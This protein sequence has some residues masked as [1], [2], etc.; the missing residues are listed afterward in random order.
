MAVKKAGKQKRR[1]DED[2][3]QAEGTEKKKKRR[4]V[5]STPKYSGVTATEAANWYRAQS[6][7][8]KVPAAVPEDTATYAFDEALY[9]MPG[10]LPQINLANPITDDDVCPEIDPTTMVRQD[11]DNEDYECLDQDF[12][13]TLGINKRQNKLW[14]KENL[15]TVESSSA[16]L[17]AVQSSHM[18]QMQR[19]HYM[20][21]FVH[22][23]TYKYTLIHS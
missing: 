10:E 22:I 18:W 6:R 4:K 13:R 8:D 5:E 9:Q 14:S 19:M 23:N 11:D 1:N 15:A 2:S 16:E 21:V 20:K 7:G 12:D 3:G 17:I